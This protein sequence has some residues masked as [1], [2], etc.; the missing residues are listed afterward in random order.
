MFLTLEG[1]TTQ[2]ESMAHAF[3]YMIELGIDPMIWYEDDKKVK[4]SIWYIIHRPK[5]TINKL[6]LA[7]CKAVDIIIDKEK[8]Y[9]DVRKHEG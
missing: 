9:E 8:E 3:V 2:H 1:D 5:E 6:D 7:I 4:N